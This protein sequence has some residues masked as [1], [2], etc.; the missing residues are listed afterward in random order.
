[1]IIKKAAALCRARKYACI[2]SSRGERC[3][4]TNAEGHTRSAVPLETVVDI[5]KQT[6]ANNRALKKIAD[7]MAE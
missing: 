1:M 2:M 4:C 3:D 6:E 5:E 7:F